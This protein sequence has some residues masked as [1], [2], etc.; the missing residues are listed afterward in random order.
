MMNGR[1]PVAISRPVVAHFK[2]IERG[3][4]AALA[5]DADHRIAGIQPHAVLRVPGAIVGDDVLEHLLA[6]QHR[7]QQDAVVI[8]V[9]LGAENGDVVALAVELQQL[10]D[11]ADAGHAVADHHQALLHDAFTMIAP[12]SPQVTDQAFTDQ[13]SSSR[14][15]P[16]RRHR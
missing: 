13:A 8:A 11:G 6:G 15:R 5:V 4:H 1:E 9:R 2:A 14:Q 7:R 12:S 10:F 3:D 16:L